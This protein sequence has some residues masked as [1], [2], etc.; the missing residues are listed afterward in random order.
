[1][2]RRGEGGQF[3]AASRAAASS[4]FASAKSFWNASLC[5]ECASNHC[6]QQCALSCLWQ[7]LCKR[8]DVCAATDQLCRRVDPAAN[9]DGTQFIQC[10]STQDDLAWRFAITNITVNGSALPPAAYDLAQSGVIVFDSPMSALLQSPSAAIVVRAA[11]YGA[12]TVVQSIGGFTASSLS[13]VAFK[14]GDVSFA[15]TNYTG[16]SFS[17]LA[18]NNLA[19]PR[20]TWPVNGAAVENPAGSGNY[21]FSDPNPATNTTRYYLLRQP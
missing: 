2:S 8:S 1:M 5:L 7:H 6:F 13:S 21:Q 3:F 14:N 15:F 11:G 17:V 16:L 19:A 12:D 10:I 9:S 18:T 20:S 4:A